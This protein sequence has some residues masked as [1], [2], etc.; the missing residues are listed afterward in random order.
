MQIE[1]LHQAGAV[2]FRGARADGQALRYQ[3]RRD[4]VVAG[5]RRLRWDVEVPPRGA[6]YDID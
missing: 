2:L 4:V 5:C 6:H 1:F 3:S